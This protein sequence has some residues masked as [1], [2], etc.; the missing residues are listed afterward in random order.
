M[1]I[2]YRVLSDNTANTD[3][4]WAAAYAGEN[5]IPTALLAPNGVLTE[6]KKN[7]PDN[8]YPLSREEAIS[9]VLRSLPENTLYAATTGRATR[10]LFCQ[11]ELWRE[12]HERDFLNIG[13]MGHASSV[14][15]GL[16][17]GNLKRRVVCL[18]GDAAAIMHMGS[19]TTVS[20]LNLPNFIHIVLNNGEHE[21]VGGQPSAG[22]LIN[23]T[24]IA[25][26]CG[27]YTVGHAVE[28]AEDLTEAIKKCMECGRASFIDMRIH[29]GI[30]SDLKSIHLKSHQLIEKLQKEL[31]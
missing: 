7:E 3:I 5:R 21:S 31:R 26:S 9:I 18:D 4:T 24:E 14:A 25:E 10:E 20:K 8:R 15:M 2:P 23:F 22:H 13:S 1:E 29:S 28:N 27:Y 19:M 17:L 11:R 16:A 12:G 6:K 30:R